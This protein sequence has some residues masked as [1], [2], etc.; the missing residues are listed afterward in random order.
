MS[1]KF[2]RLGIPCPHCQSRASGDKVRRITRT[3][4]EVT[5]RCSNVRC[6]CNFVVSVETV[7]ML[8][9]P[10][11]PDPTVNVPLSPHIRR[12]ALQAVM[13]HGRIADLRNGDFIAGQAENLDLFEQQQ[14]AHAP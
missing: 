10:S 11:I 2:S 13:E 3:L 7:R 1:A 4:S 12:G 6:G 8:T 14:E 9:L 5:Y